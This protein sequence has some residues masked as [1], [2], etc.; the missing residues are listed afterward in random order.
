MKEG[1]IWK[2]GSPEAMLS[3]DILRQLYGAPLSVATE[4]SPL[5]S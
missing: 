5:F 4:S 3:E 2:Q 1:K